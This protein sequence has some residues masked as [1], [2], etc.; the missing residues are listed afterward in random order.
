MS[1]SLQLKAF[2]VLQGIFLLILTSSFGAEPTR[3]T[4][5]QAVQMAVDRNLELKAKKEEIGIA[6]GRQVRANLLIQFNPEIEG[7]ISNR[8]LENSSDGSNRNV[9]Q[10]G[11]TFSQEFEIAGQPEHRREA[12]NRNLEKVKFEI[13]DFERILRFRIAEI[14][15]KLSNVREKIRQ[16]EHI[17]D[18]RGRLYE[19]SK[20]RLALGDIPEVQLI[21]AE[22]ELNRSKSDL[23]TLQKEYEE[24]LSRLTSELVLEGDEK[25]DLVSSLVRQPFP[26]SL[27]ELLKAVENRTDIAAF[28]QERKVAEA[29][30][31]LTRAERIPN[32]K[33]GAFY[34]K[35]DKDNIVG[36]KITIPIP[37][38]DRRQGEIRQALARKSIA[39]IN[40][41]NLRQVAVKALR[42]AYERFK[43]S[44]S[45]IALYP[46]EAMKRFDES[47]A[48]Y[49]RAYQESA[50]DLADAIV[51]QN[52]VIEARTKFIDALTNYNLSVAELKFQAGIE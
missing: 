37:F 10:G 52:Q 4:L 41:V 51:F 9:P 26:H 27:D 6:E 2:S 18:L 7:D 34:A 30:E 1:I 3:L 16:A 44:E 29:E 35:D 47:L 45:E 48:L 42:A 49:Q 17:V 24:L 19:A 46:Q 12:A 31:L 20:T 23:I 15:L 5:E 28:D 11:V 39:N 21:V 40:Y 36:G 25:I 50:I 14:F 33:V 43:L 32:I 22:F 8:R 38:F 13:T